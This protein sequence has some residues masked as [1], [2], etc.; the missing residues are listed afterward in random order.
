METPGKPSMAAHFAYGVPVYSRDRYH[1]L[2]GI[3]R[4][5]PGLVTLSPQLSSHRVLVRNSQE[6]RDFDETPAG[7]ITHYDLPEHE[8]GAFRRAYAEGRG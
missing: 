1:S 5:C 2:Y 4:P 3:V 8:G 7:R 6:M